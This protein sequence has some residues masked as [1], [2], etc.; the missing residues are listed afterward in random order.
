MNEIDS[1]T[2][3]EPQ[4]A[5]DGHTS[6]EYPNNR[7]IEV[8]R[9]IDAYKE[10][11]PADAIAFLLCNRYYGFFVEIPHS[12]ILYEQYARSV[13]AQS[14]QLRIPAES[15][16]DSASYIQLGPENV[17]ELTEGRS[18]SA[19]E[20]KGCLNT[21]KRD[22]IREPKQYIFRKY[23]MT[24]LR[25]KARQR[26]DRVPLFT[27][28]TGNMSFARSEDPVSGKRSFLIAN[29]SAADLFIDATFAS[30]ATPPVAVADEEQLLA[31][32]TDS[33]NPS[34]EPQPALDDWPFNI[35]V[36]DPY[37]FEKL[38]PIVF[39]AMQIAQNRA[40]HPRNDVEVASFLL[41]R[42]PNEYATA[43]GDKK[44][45]HFLA[46]LTRPEYKPNPR[47]A[48]KKNALASSDAD[49]FTARDCYSSMMRLLVTVAKK[50]V[51]S[52]L[53]DEGFKQAMKDRH[54]EVGDQGAL[55][56][57]FSWIITGRYIPIDI[58]GRAD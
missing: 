37:N 18:T 40:I 47:L 5:E 44:R 33:E 55:A 21:K 9:L 52:D 4:A 49:E 12:A 41:K 54:F 43:L 15:P 10:L 13:P 1:D 17:N 38:C 23:E 51:E 7:A 8:I 11:K 14:P 22:S 29:I 25:P 34:Q 3:D 56:G 20:F 36:E 45:L 50:W 6:N 35:E 46:A 32:P 19:F 39:E 26:L 58:Q 2:S 53:T 16:I 30:L 27:S 24:L 31:E 48:W 57:Q 28:A 42:H